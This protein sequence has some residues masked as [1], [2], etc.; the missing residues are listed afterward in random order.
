MAWILDLDGVVWLGDTS[1]PGAAGAVSR[2]RADGIRVVFLTNN[3]AH[4][5]ADYVARLT[6]MGIPVNR[7]DVLTSAEAATSL[8]EPGSTALVCAGAGVEESL[9]RRGVRA[10]RSGR[11]DAVVVGWHRE[12]DFSRLAAAVS[13]VLGGAR[14]I[15]TNDD[16]TFPT[17][18][19]PLPGAGSILA[20]VAYGSGAT[21]T[22]A[23]KPNE[24]VVSLLKD[25]VGAIDVVVGDR[26]ST[27]G[28]LARRLGARF[29]LVLSGVTGPH[30]GHL[31]PPP[32]TEAADLSALVTDELSGGGA[33]AGGAE[34]GPT[35]T[36]GR[37]SQ[38]FP[39]MHGE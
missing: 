7:S 35:G 24:P 32:D 22:V 5:V 39:T 36:Q 30:H 10:V 2:L 23:G 1:I 28:A 16:A 8:L 12:F 37:A 38:Q 20:A 17:A 34:P 11:A 19:G 27:D 14:L 13:A 15:A 31:D 33:R 9:A 29:A 6:R 26:P 3:S 21:P 4:T 25:R 18:H